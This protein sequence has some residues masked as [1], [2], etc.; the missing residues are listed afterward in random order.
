VYVKTASGTNE[1]SLEG[2]LGVPTDWSSDGHSILGRN[3]EGDLWVVTDGKPPKIMQTP[4]NES[5]GQ[6]SPDG[7]WIAF[8][9]DESKRSEVYVQAFPKGGEQFP[10]STSGG[11]QPRWRRDGKELFYVAADGTLMAV[12]VKTGAAFEYASP[13]RLFSLAVLTDTGSSLF[14]DY[15]VDGD[16]PRFLVRTPA[17]DAKPTPIIVTTNWFTV[18]KK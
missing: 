16:A 1:Q 9:S 2:V 3:N 17:K 5:Q 6:F 15:Q 7:K 8:V 11:S 12:G 18:A 4:F 10:I 14:F 13:K